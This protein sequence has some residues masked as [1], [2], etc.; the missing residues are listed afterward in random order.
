MPIETAEPIETAMLVNTDPATNMNRF[1]ALE[2]HADGRVEARWGRVGDHGQTKTYTGG[3]ATYTRLLNDKQRKGYRTMRPGR[4]TTTA[5][6]DMEAAARR[7]L[8]DPA[9]ADDL[10]AEMI[11]LLVAANRHQI[12]AVSGGQITTTAGV[13]TELGPVDTATIIEARAALARM[14]GGDLS[15]LGHYL[16]LIPQKLP[17]TRGW[18]TRFT[19]PDVLAAQSEFLDQ[20]D[21]A[22]ALS[23]P[24]Q[25]ARVGFRYQLRRA[26]RATVETL[27]R[28]YSKAR[29]TAHD[30]RHLRLHD[31]WQITDLTGS[32]GWKHQRATLSGP[33]VR[34]WHGSRTYNLLSI[35]HRGLFVPPYGASG[36]YTTTGRMFGHGIYQSDIS[37][38]ALGYSYG[39]WSR[40]PHRDP[41]CFMFATDTLLGN[42]LRTTPTDTK[43]E[44]TRR[45][46]HPRPGEPRYHSLSVRAGTCQVYNNE[47]IVPHPD[48]V[49]LTY[50]CEFLP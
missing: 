38:K 20:L 44:V 29:H 5:G 8:T 11:R 21:T 47:T 23:A 33:P 4:T 24:A 17:R 36:T 40:T 3:A 31:A 10:T 46:F 27:R 41:H 34:L 9:A 48:Q 6:I 19:R 49:Q 16:R 15:I 25:A 12:T 39:T 43:E 42:T 30:C 45:L 22:I 14:Q 7:E 28:R 35:L 32:D 26:D 1:Y 37:T 50:L 18:E 2:L 13:A